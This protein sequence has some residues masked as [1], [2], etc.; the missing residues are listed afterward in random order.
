[1]R[2]TWWRVLDYAFVCRW[3][4]AAVVSRA[5]PDDFSAG[6]GPTIVLLPGVYEPWRFLLP[7]A[8]LLHDRG[9]RVHVLPELG[10]NRRAIPA[11]AAA[12]GRYLV[13]HDLRDVTLVAHSKG[14][15]IG[16]LAMSR[17]DPDDRIADMIAVNTPFAGSRYARWFLDGAVRAFVPTNATIVALAAEVDTNARI[18]SA[19]SV[20]DPHVPEG[21]ELAGAVDVVLDTPGHFRP[22]ADERLVDLLVARLS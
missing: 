2:H 13:A 16:K 14:G 9:A 20:W 15:L 7:W 3:Q 22:L 19:H 18:T 4:I 6:T 21:S 5:R 11:A 8:R 17:E 1:M 12:L 10:V